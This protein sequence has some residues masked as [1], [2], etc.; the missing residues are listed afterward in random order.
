MRKNSSSHFNNNESKNN[1]EENNLLLL[2]GPGQPNKDQIS[3]DVN[4]TLKS[5]IILTY[6]PKIKKSLRKVI[7][8]KNIWTRP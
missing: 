2:P 6:F 1:N 8:I 5:L 4:I 7:K 3:K